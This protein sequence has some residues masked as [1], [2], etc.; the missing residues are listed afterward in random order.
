MTFQVEEIQ[1]IK[2]L[3]LA[4]IKWKKQEFVIKFW[5][6]DISTSEEFEA[7]ISMH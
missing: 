4:K 6:G 7:E 5:D 2:T 1:I 3:Y